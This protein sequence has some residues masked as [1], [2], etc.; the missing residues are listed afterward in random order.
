[1]LFNDALNSS[2]F[3]ECSVSMAVNNTLWKEAVVAC[4]EAVPW[5][6]AQGTE[7]N[8]YYVSQGNRSTDLGMNTALLG[9][10][11]SMLCNRP[12]RTVT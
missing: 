3:T 7:N 4:F 2:D 1:M 9:Y 5:H 8:Y 12:R 11:A 10:E 6:F